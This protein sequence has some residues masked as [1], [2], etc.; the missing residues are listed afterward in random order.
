MLLTALAL[1]VSVLRSWVTQHFLLTHTHIPVCLLPML[2][3][4]PYQQDIPAGRESC[5]KELLLPCALPSHVL[6]PERG[7]AL[8]T[9]V[10]TSMHAEPQFFPWWLLPHSALPQTFLSPDAHL[11]VQRNSDAGWGGLRLMWAGVAELPSFS[12]ALSSPR[13]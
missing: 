9:A 8:E 10:D 3:H 2:T 7:H 11:I 1:N 12:T 13:Q 4:K 5:Q 6:P